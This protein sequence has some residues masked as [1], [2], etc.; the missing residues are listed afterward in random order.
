MIVETLVTIGIYIA[1]EAVITGVGWAFYMLKKRGLKKR[2]SEWCKTLPLIE[3][4]KRL[5]EQNR[6]LMKEFFPSGIEDGFKGLTLEQRVEM[7]KNLIERANDLYGVEVDTIAFMPAA[8]IGECTLGFF[9]RD[10]NA[11]AV[12]LDILASNEA[13]VMQAIVATVFHELRHALQYRAVTDAS[14][15]YGTEEQRRLWALN[16]V[17]GN[18]I[19]P[20]IDFALYQRQVVEADARQIAE[21]I[22]EN[23]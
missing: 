1:V 19:S 3:E 12:N 21:H 9:D 18:Y 20:E 6:E 23:F 15:N 5:I 13:A 17:E 4:D 11:I 10:N 22:V 16:F 7:M 14:F 8:K 2:T